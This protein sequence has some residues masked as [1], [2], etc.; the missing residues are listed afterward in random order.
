MCHLDDGVCGCNW[1]KQQAGAR[2]VV[3]EGSVLPL[4]NLSIM[5]ALYLLVFA[6]YTYL[7]FVKI[8][9]G[10]SDHCKCTATASTLA[11]GCGGA[12]ALSMYMAC[13]IIDVVVAPWSL[14]LFLKVQTT[15]EV[16]GATLTL[17][18]CLNVSLMW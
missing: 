14:I 9:A 16:L 6:Y 15:L 3:G 1:V 7:I 12:F 4:A 10:G 13:E 8:R 18:S 2:C 17:T 5:L 11:L